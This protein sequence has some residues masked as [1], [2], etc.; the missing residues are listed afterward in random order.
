MATPIESMIKAGSK[1]WLDSVDPEL[2]DHWKTR[3]IS[4]ATSNPIIVADLVQTGRFD[5]QLEQFFNQGENDDQVAWEAT[6]LLVQEAQNKFLDVWNQTQGNDGY[7]SFEL[8]PLLEDE[9]LAPA[10]EERVR[11]YVELGKQW[12]QGHDNRMIKVPGTRAGIEALEPLAAAGITLNVTLLFTGR[13]YQAARDA[14]WRGAQKRQSLDNFKS[15]Y[16]IFISRVDVYTQKQVPEL[17]DAAQ[18]LV[19]LV[20]AK[21][22]WKDNHDFWSDKNLRLEQE[23]IFASTGTKIE[24]DPK[25]KYV[26]AVVGDG[27]QT[28]PPDTLDAIDSSGKAYTREIDRLPDQ[29]VLD[30]IDQKV[31]EGQVE[32]VLVR[33]GAKKFADPHKQL[34]K[35]IAEK[36]KVLAPS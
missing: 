28:N 7:V 24:S 1:I 26:A 5:E 4:G 12:A 36:R 20:N 35:V 6:N 14:V 34:L 8:D 33:E 16:S 9:D 25:D 2:I 30:E 29:A 13:Q 17:S 19:G 31:D 11:R 23:I 10:H 21:R 18:G 27:I 32:E 22:L 3:G 15:V